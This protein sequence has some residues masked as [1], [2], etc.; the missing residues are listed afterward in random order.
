MGMEMRL[1][2]KVSSFLRLV[3]TVSIATIVIVY[4]SNSYTRFSRL[5]FSYP[6]F[7]LFLHFLFILCTDYF[8]PLYISFTLVAVVRSTNR[9]VVRELIERRSDLAVASMVSKMAWE[10][11]LAQFYYNSVLSHECDAKNKKNKIK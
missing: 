7:L 2:E 1:T 10:K 3:S 8:F 4:Y 11:N 9:F 6:V 5:V